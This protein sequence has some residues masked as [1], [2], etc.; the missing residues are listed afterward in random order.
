MTIRKAGWT[1][2]F[3]REGETLEGIIHN[4]HLDVK[5][6]IKEIQK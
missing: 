5:R 4:Q 3:M 6:I 2:I 1:I